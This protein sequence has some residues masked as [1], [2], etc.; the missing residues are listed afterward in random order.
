MSLAITN[1][2]V[3][4]CAVMFPDRKK[5]MIAVQKGNVITCYGSFRSEE[6]ADRFIRE[7]AEFF[8]LK[9]AEEV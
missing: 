2:N 8:G 3:K 7:L 1:G 5:P 6:S 9:H 4:I